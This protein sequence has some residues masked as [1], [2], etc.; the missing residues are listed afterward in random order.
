MGNPEFKTLF[1]DS[2]NRHYLADESATLENL[3]PLARGDATKNAAVAETAAALVRYVRERDSD[4]GG[5]QA[6]LRHYDLS[7]EEGIVLMCLAEALLRIPDDATV[8]ALIADRIGAADWQRHLGASESLFVNASTWALMLTGRVLRREPASHEPAQLL[9]QLLARLEEPV[10][11]ASLKAAMRIMAAEFVM[12]RSITEALARA[13]GNE[14]RGQRFSFDM[15]GEAALTAA[16]AGAYEQAYFDAI[17]AIGT[18]VSEPIEQAARPGISVKLSALCPRF[19][20]RH[21]TRATT[22]LVDR[23]SRLAVA[24]RDADVAV[25]LDAEEADR[26]LLSLRVFERV[27]H[28][29]AL[30]GW[31]G[32]G[33]AV[34][35]Y[36]KRALD[37]LD[38]VNELGG[39]KDRT[40]PVR[41]V[42]GA[43]WD[44]EIKRAQMLGLPDYPVFT[45]KAHTDIS[46]LAC[47]RHV[48]SACRFVYPQFATHNAHTVSY[49]FHHAGG[50][51]YEFQRLHGMGELLYQY[52]TTELGCAC[53]VY[54]PVGAHEDLLPYLVRRLLENG[55]NASFVNQI[56]HADTHIDTLIADPVSLVGTHNERRPRRVIPLPR[57]LYGTQRENSRG[58]AFDD[59]VARAPFIDAV[60]TLRATKQLAAPRIGGKFADGSRRPVYNPARRAEC[61][62]HVVDAD[63]TMAREA[64]A[65][66]AGAAAGWAR[67]P[68]HERASAL[69]RAADRLERDFPALTA[70][71]VLEAGKTLVNG[72]DDVREAID[73][74]RYY[75]AT[76]RSLF[77][78]P[79]AL[80]GP[81]GESNE[82]CWRGR[83]VFVCISPWNF[84]AAIY[85]GQ[86][87]AAL[88]AGNSVIAKPAEQTSLVAARITDVLYESGVPASVLS[89]LPGDGPE[90]GRTLVS[91]PRVAG[92]A[93]TGS[94]A[95]ALHI[96]RTLAARD[97]PLPALIAET[98]GIN[99]MIADS[100]ALPE[101]LVRDVVDSAFDSA[102]QRCSAL[103]LLCVHEAIAER[104]LEL[105]TGAMAEW[106]VDDP[107]RIDTDMGPVID[108]DARDR[109]EH[110]VAAAEADGALLFRGRVPA[111][112][113]YFVAPAII[114][115]GVVDEIPG[116]IFG[117]VLHVVRYR[118]ETEGALVDA[119]NAL[120]YGLTLGVQSR[121][122]QRAIAICR[123]ARVGNVYV[124]RSMVGAVVGTQAFGG[125]GW[126]GTGP[127][128]GGPNYLTRFATEQT[129]TVNTAALGGNTILLGG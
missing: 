59:P 33:I 102:G 108:G 103:R 39:C 112:D 77:T 8:D 42:K 80:P 101:Q 12:G 125:M 73:F 7:S 74:L 100:S 78:E 53:R 48:L 24:A 96:N 22:E 50:R 21:E 90:L 28:D 2:T 124:N 60:E 17:G 85:T 63:A 107:S 120:G 56:A 118:G 128:A 35:A 105:L 70:A 10:L 69:E 88:V 95:T 31:S 89:F 46:Y 71:C 1:D 9:S 30:D 93:F 75:A 40:V 99:A 79:V 55:A 65:V 61:L 29:P 111:A 37:V 14:F 62:G 66:A 76:A 92:V 91:D 27:W 121:I 126:S 25:T 86:V 34:Q 82:L 52:V 129:F 72:I 23:V 81:T 123:R 26:L 3:L 41:L 106:R 57:E 13:D 44:T 47:A 64:L 4:V 67:V 68:V 122:E 36:Q 117:P 127:K 20:A 87:A 6:F 94:T 15:L 58:F 51:E 19:D 38:R 54:A 5:L 49:V 97:A 45:A 83:G 109:I 11:R 119:I 110:V 84:P 32:F 104:T 16:A 114:E 18:S 113:G 98:G 43:Y 115:L 116:E